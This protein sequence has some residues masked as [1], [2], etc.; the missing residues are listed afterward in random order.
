MERC[1]SIAWL[2]CSKGAE[3]RGGGT[4]KGSGIFRPE[5]PCGS[6]LLISIRSTWCLD[7]QGLQQLSIY[8]TLQASAIPFTQSPSRL[9]SRPTHPS[10]NL[11]QLMAVHVVLALSF[12]SLPG[13]NPE[14]YPGSRLPVTLHSLRGSHSI[15]IYYPVLPSRS[16]YPIH[17]FPLRSS[18][19]LSNQ[20]SD[21]ARGRKGS[22]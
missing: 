19:R 12:A 9:S 16:C 14:L 17:L 8:T 2:P 7:F 15:T 3:R 21:Q 4:G 11:L 10:S 5:G 18:Q 20:L 1:S 6:N 13:L 22:T